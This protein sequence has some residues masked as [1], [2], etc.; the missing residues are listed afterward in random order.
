MRAR[1]VIILIVALAVAGTLYVTNPGRDEYVRWAI[2]KAQSGG[3]Y[4]MSR[5]IGP[6][7]APMYVDRATVGRDFLLFS[8]YYTTMETGDNVVTLGICRQFVPLRGY[9][10]DR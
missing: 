6:E 1:R 8:L 10:L 3:G 2:D 9:G 4:Y 5:M 7:A